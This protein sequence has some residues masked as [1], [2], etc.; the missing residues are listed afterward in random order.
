M[1]SALSGSGVED[2][3]A[4]LAGAMP[5]GPWLYPEDQIADLPLRLLAAEITRE[6]LYLRLHEELPYALTVETESWTERKDGSVR[7][8]QT[9]YVERESQ[10]QDRARQG[11]PD[12]QGDRPGSPQGARRGARAAGA[13]VPVCQGQGELGGS[14]SGAR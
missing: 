10:T 12:H 1:I 14:R 6:K 3:R 2:L 9:I 8:D 7:I 4:T 11:R 13:P 5:E